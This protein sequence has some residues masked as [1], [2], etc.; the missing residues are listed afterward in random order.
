MVSVKLS[1]VKCISLL[2]FRTLTA[3]HFCSDK[4]DPVKLVAHIGESSQRKTP[5][6]AANLMTLLSFHYSLIVLTYSLAPQAEPKDTTS[7]V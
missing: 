5:K 1:A 7:H 6:S 4:E 2:H 3:P